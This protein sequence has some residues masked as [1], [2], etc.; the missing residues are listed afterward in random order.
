MQLKYSQIKNNIKKAQKKIT[1]E[2]RK[3]TK[4]LI[5]PA[6]NSGLAQLGF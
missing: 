4:P 2:L 3:T 6:P 1:F 5:R